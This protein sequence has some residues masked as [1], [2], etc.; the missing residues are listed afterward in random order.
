MKPLLRG[1]AALL[2]G[3]ALAPAARADVVVRAPFVR[4]QVGPGVYVRAPFVRVG[5][6]PRLSASPVVMPY[7]VLEPGAPPPVPLIVPASPVAP[8]GKVAEVAKAMTIAEFA[9]TFKPSLDGGK[10]EVVL[11]HPCTCC[12]VKVCFSLPPGCPKRVVARK[13]ELVIRYGPL[14]AVVIRFNRD[15]SYKVRA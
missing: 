11:E 7:P 12:P 13:S 5:V 2:T 15:G 3:V 1:A 10:Y 14:R 9:R 4:V 8:V 6:P